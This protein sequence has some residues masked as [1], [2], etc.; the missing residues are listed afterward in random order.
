MKTLSAQK[1]ND[2]SLLT[3]SSLEMLFKVTIPVPV[4]VQE[5]ITWSGY[6]FLLSMESILRDPLSPDLNTSPLLLSTVEATNLIYFPLFQ[7]RS[8]LVL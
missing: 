3:L 4:L 7:F 6:R 5:G 2:Y 8:Y 1:F